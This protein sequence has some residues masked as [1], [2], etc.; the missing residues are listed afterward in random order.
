MVKL[1]SHYE[2]VKVKVS[3]NFRGRTSCSVQKNQAVLNATNK[4]NNAKR[5][6]S[7]SYFDLPTL[8]ANILHNKLKQ[9]I[10]EIID[11]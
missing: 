4:L 1:L 2:R 3:W 6:F 5:V 9:A 8:Y 11:F 10:K 7:V